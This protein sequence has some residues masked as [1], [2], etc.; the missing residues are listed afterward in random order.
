MNTRKLREILT[1]KRFIKEN[2]LIRSSLIFGK[3]MYTPPL[4]GEK[5]ARRL[6]GTRKI[7][8]EIIYAIEERLRAYARQ[9]TP[10]LDIKSE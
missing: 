1:E 6:E 4:L 2:P 3:G 5:R 7:P 8:K 9:A 10:L